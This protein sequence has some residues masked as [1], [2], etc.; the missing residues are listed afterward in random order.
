MITKKVE[1]N[2][3]NLADFEFNNLLLKDTNLKQCIGCFRCLR[4]GKGFCPLKDDR[5]KI[6]EQINESDAVIFATPV[7]VM[8]VT[9]LMKNFID[10][11]AYICHRPQFFDKHA[12]IV[13]T[14]GAIGNKEVQ[15]Y[16]SMVVQ[17]WGFRSVTNLGVNTPP[18]LNIPK[19]IIKK[20]NEKVKKASK[21]FYDKLISKEWKPNLDHM[22][23][24]R[25][26][27]A[28]FT[29]DETKKD[30]PADYKFYKPLK[31]KN[32]YVKAKVNF[33]KD[34]IAWI[35]EKIIISSIINGIKKN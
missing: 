10:R 1:E 5:D 4:D 11:F 13:S 24:F 34:K 25:A 20:R 7:Y 8:N 9:A 31:K 22:I 26:Q 33:L 28:I 35:L 21:K 14:T 16:M 18:H 30:M 17:V 2:L 29:I 15:K 27:R 19:N 23:Q 6:L 3:K 32:F 12:M